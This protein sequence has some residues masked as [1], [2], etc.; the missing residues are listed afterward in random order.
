M[1][2]SRL[3]D[4]LTAL[5]AAITGQTAALNLQ[6]GAVNANT[7]MLTRLVGLLDPVPVKLQVQFEGRLPGMTAQVQEG[8]LIGAT[9]MEFNAENEQVPAADPTKLTYA[10]DDPTVG[11][12]L[13]N[14]DDSTIPVGQ[15]RIKGLKVGTCNVTSTDSALT[16]PLV[17]DPVAL[18]VTLDPV[19]N[20]LVVTLA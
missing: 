3:I 5:T 20:K 6:T 1:V 16:P 15:A 9:D 8:L 2:M 11:Q 19:A 18:A 17:S 12:V 4:A 13:T 10:V 7:A 14:A